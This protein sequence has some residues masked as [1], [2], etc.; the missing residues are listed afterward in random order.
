MSRKQKRLE[1]LL[2]T[3]KDLTWDELISAMSALGFS[4]ITKGGSHHDFYHSEKDILIKE[5]V[6]PHGGS[7]H[8]KIVYLKKIIQHI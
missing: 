6:K 5:I 4:V 3:P 7:K 1:R 2:Q 8:V